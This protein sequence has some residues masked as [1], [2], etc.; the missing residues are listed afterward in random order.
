MRTDQL[1]LRNEYPGTGKWEIPLIKKQVIDLTNASLIPSSITRNN[2]TAARKGCGVHFFVD[3]YRFTSIY[4]NPHS[5]LKKFSQYAFLITPD[6]STYADMKP[7]RQLESVAHSRWCGAFWQS[8]GLTVIPSV[9]WSTPSSYSYCFDGIEKS[10]F[11]AV[12]TIGCRRNKQTFIRGYRAMLE[13]LQ[14][15]RILCVGKP[16]PEMQGNLLVI[17]YTPFSREVI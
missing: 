6:F 12:S 13:R 11:V 10:S 17:P 16:F 7:W 14:P 5:N 2:D 9:T 4:N 1:F 8:N 15:E 3:D